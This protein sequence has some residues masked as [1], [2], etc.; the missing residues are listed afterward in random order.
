MFSPK[1]ITQY[2][3]AV[4]I[5]PAI[6]LSTCSERSEYGDASDYE[7]LGADDTISPTII[8]VSPVE[9]PPKLLMILLLLQHSVKKFQPGQ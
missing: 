5:L 3:T 1:K 7:K 6:L 9:I 8:S 4:L 2:F